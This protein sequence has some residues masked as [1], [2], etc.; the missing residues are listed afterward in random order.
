MMIES[1][2]KSTDDLFALPFVWLQAPVLD[3]CCASEDGIERCA[4]ELDRVV[5]VRQGRNMMIM[6]FC[7]EHFAT[8]EARCARQH[9]PCINDAPRRASEPSAP[10][11]FC[12]GV[13]IRRR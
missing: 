6:A 2:S 7:A 11:G 10:V 12:D 4:A 1:S 5:V 8:F 13:R 3:H 9:N